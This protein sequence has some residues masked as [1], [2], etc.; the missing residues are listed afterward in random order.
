MLG[1]QCQP[2]ERP[3]LFGRI[4]QLPTTADLPQCQACSSAVEHFSL[5]PRER[6]GVRRPR[7]S[8][9]IAPLNLVGTRSTVSLASLS[10]G[11]AVERVPTRLRRFMGR[12]KQ[13][14]RLPQPQ[15]IQ[16]GGT[17][18]LHPP[19]HWGPSANPCRYSARSVTMPHPGTSTE[20]PTAWRGRS[21]VSLNHPFRR[22][23][24]LSM[25]IFARCANP[26]PRRRPRNR[27]LQDEPFHPLSSILFGCG[28]AAPC[29]SVVILWT[30]G[31]RDD[32]PAQLSNRH[33]K[34][35]SRGLQF[36]RAAGR[37][38][39]H[40]HCCGTVVAWLEPRQSWRAA[41][42]LLK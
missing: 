29:P 36:D 9:R 18:R 2:G 11:D 32:P 17:F 1:K 7:T 23:A 41:N 5:S 4:W 27:N 12:G 3:L 6:A 24:L 34:N 13:T 31:R 15:R 14:I 22:A 38:R 39:H 28:S 10:Y 16:T 40:C 8:S 35:R 42:K 30:S 26:R 37:H 21:L 19:F 20:P 33:A 25:R